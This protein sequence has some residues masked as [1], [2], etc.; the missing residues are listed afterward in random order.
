MEKGDVILIKLNG[1][2][3][4]PKHFVEEKGSGCYYDQN[5]ASLSDKKTKSTWNQN[6]SKVVTWI[7]NFIEPN[8][9]RPLQSP[10]WG[11]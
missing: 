5:I 10:F 6:N 1:M 9:D 4:S 7:L 11:L 3:L 2:A 8:T